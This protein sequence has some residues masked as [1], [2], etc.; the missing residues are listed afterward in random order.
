MKTFKLFAAISLFVLGA[1]V[2]SAASANTISFED[3]PLLSSGNFSSGGFDFSLVGVASAVVVGGTGYCSPACPNN[4]TQFV[5]A[6]YSEDAG[7]GWPP[8]SLTMV[9]SGGGSFS[10][11]GFDGAGSFAFGPG[12]LGSIPTQ[13]NVLGVQTGG[14]TVFQSFLIDR[15]PNGNVPP[16]LN[17]TSNL[18]SSSFSD[19]VSLRFSSSGSTQLVYN[20]FSID[21][22][23][24]SVGSGSS[25]PEPA[26]LLLLGT[27]LAA[28]AARRRFKR[29]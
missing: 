16:E 25:V 8:A 24:V 28:V 5:L 3:V 15:V 12:S 11:A 7:Q 26:T 29:T 20:G 17:F 1:V 4:G 27:G 23:N 21:N 14:G 18:A 9:K 2:P 22:I 19:L 6:P 10:F 13:I